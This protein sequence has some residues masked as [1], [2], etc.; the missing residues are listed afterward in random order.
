MVYSQ[1][2]GEF[3]YD[4]RTTLD[5]EE[6]RRARCDAVVTFSIHLIS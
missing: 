4:N 2:P 6:F 5:P 1:V 3:G